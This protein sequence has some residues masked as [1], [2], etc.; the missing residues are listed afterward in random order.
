MELFTIATLWKN[1][2]RRVQPLDVT[3]IN[4]EEKEGYTVEYVFFNGDPC[5]DGCARIF[6][7]FYRP[8]S[9]NGAGVVLMNDVMDVFDETYVFML[10]S[11]GYNVLVVDY[12]GN[13]APN[14]IR[15]T[16]ILS[17]IPTISSTRILPANCPKIPRNLAG[18]F[19]QRLCCAA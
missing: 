6:S 7:K 13:A 3:V 2:D 15:C 19:G 18:T 14:F 11:Y 4:I 16:L 9:G 12:V 1:Y 5:A 8:R 17:K 10:I